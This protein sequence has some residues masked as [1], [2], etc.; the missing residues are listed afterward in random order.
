MSQ[1]GAPYFSACGTP[2][3]KRYRPRKDDGDGDDHQS[4]RRGG[5]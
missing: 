4:E 5:G 2:T 3:L 1:D